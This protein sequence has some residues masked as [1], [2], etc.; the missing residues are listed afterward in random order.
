MGT[1]APSVYQQVIEKTKGMMSRTQ[2]L[3]RNIEKR[4]NIDKAGYEVSRNE[5]VVW[6]PHKLNYES[7]QGAH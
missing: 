7:F 4:L 3:A 2:E 6:R 5:E 1:Q